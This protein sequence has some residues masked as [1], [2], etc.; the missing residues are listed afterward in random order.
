MS[1]RHGISDYIN[2][3]DDMFIHLSFM[4]FYKNLNHIHIKQIFRICCIFDNIVSDFPDYNNEIII[5]VPLLFL[6]HH[7]AR[8]INSI[9]PL[10]GMQH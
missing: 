6:D 10:L 7:P 4:I 5:L 9:I 2:F 1:D 3:H 8:L